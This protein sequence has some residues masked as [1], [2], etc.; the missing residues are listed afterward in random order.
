MTKAEIQDIVSLAFSEM[1]ERRSSDKKEYTSLAAIT[2]YL[3]IASFAGAIVLY[4]GDA[5]IDAKTRPFAD[6]QIK[7]RQVQVHILSDLKEI[8]EAVRKK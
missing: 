2:T 6:E 5:R 4:I 8:K 3:A 7:S 1:G